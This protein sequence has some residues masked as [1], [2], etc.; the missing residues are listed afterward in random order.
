[1]LSVILH[2]VWLI[3]ISRK[4]IESNFVKLKICTHKIYIKS[5]TYNE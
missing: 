5:Y 2:A 1:M 3:E 4:K